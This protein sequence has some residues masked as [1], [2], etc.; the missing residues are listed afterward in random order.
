MIEQDSV[1]LARDA[2]IKELEGKIEAL[3][4]EHL[5]N[6]KEIASANS[7]V[8]ESTQKVDSIAD[9]Q[10]KKERLKWSGI[11]LYTGL[12]SKRFE[13]RNSEINLEL[14]YEFRR[15]HFGFKASFEDSDPIQEGLEFYYHLK[16]RYKIF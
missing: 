14:M 5:K 1:I 7:V 16:L 3:K 15:F 10:L 12:E 4:A 8:K 11:H 2:K 9:Y 13:F 6:L